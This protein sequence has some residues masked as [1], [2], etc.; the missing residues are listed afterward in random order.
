MPIEV[1][2]IRNRVA[3]VTV[4]IAPGATVVLEYRPV[5]LAEYIESGEVS[6]ERPASLQASREVLARQLVEV[7]VQWDVTRKGEPF[8]LDVYEI[9]DTFDIGFLNKITTSI[10]EHYLQG[11][12]S[13]ELLSRLGD[14]TFSRPVAAESSPVGAG[15]RVSRRSA[16]S[17]KSRSKVASPRGNLRRIP[18]GTTS[19]PPAFRPASAS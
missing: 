3:A 19:S 8:P 9:A 10:A 12:V 14:A 15:N 18:S 7:T 16:S 6:T 4:E 1:E 13:G 11:K 17:S 5:R 2:A